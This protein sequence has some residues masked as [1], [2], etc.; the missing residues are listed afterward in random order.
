[1]T[2]QIDLTTPGPPTPGRGSFTLDELRLNV[3]R[4]EIL[5]WLVDN[6]GERFGH[7]ITADDGAVELMR[8]LNKADLSTKSLSTPRNDDLV[9]TP[10]ALAPNVSAILLRDQDAI[11]KRSARAGC[12]P[13]LEQS[14]SSL[15]PA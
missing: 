9:S 13:R 1:M 2:E 10:G 8:A 7:T 5:I 15:L 4:Q 11:R 3:G 6:N 12:L 14:L